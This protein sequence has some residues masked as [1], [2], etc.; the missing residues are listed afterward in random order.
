MAKVHG[1]KSK[2][3]VKEEGRARW[4]FLL[5]FFLFVV[6]SLIYLP[7]SFIYRGNNWMS[8]LIL[9][10]FW[11]VGILLTVFANKKKNKVINYFKGRKAE[12]NIFYELL[13]LPS[14]YHLLQ[15]LKIYEKSNIDFVVVGPTGI[16]AIEVKS[17]GGVIGFDGGQ[18]TRNGERFE[19]DFL[20]Q[21]LSGYKKIRTI[22][23]EK[24]NK[25][26]FIIPVLV[27]ANKFAKIR[28]GFNKQRKVYVIGKKFL[29]RVI[30]EHGYREKSTDK[31]IQAVV[32]VLKNFQESVL[33]VV[34]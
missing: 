1:N 10:V 19:K 12:Y 34:K 28:F 22:L 5:S 33:E 6:S 9:I 8:L 21:T 29:R 7:L 26:Y 13:K 16:F 30:S 4:L 17:Q 32:D 24:L 2:Y 25:E 31:E 11:G 14:N 23:E 20:Q 18:L 3:L 27:F 15:S